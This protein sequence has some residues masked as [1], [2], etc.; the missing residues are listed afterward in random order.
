MQGSSGPLIK[1]YPRCSSRRRR[2]TR[3]G[4]C[5]RGRRKCGKFCSV[6][7]WSYE[8]AL[9][10]ARRYDPRWAANIER[11]NVRDFSALVTDMFRYVIVY[12]HG[13][14]YQ[15]VS[16]HFVSPAAL[17]RV[18]GLYRRHDAVFFKRL[19]PCL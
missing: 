14:F 19:L 1:M 16:F 10:E 15:D 18:V 8:E 7:L 5:G 3:T 11:I 17:C 6:K 2:R 12:Y 13:G 9:A 4:A